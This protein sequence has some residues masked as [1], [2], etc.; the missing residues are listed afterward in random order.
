MILTQQMKRRQMQQDRSIVLMEELKSLSTRCQR[1][2]K[3]QMNLQ[4]RFWMLIAPLIVHA[5]KVLVVT[6]SIRILIMF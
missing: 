4:P 6:H 3:G 2:R 1:S 5:T